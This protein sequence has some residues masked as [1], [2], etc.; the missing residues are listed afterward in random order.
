MRNTE[1]YGRFSSCRGVAFEIKPHADLF[2]I[3]DRSRLTNQSRRS[4]GQWRSSFA[5]IIPSSDLIERSL[6]RESSHFCDLD[7]DEDEDGDVETLA[8]IEESNKECIVNP[9]KLHLIIFFPRLD[10]P[11]SATKKEPPSSRLSVILLDQGLFT[12]YKRLFAVCLALN[13]TALV[14]AATGKFPYA[15]DR[16]ALFSIANIFALVLCC[17]E[18]VL[19]VVFWLAVTA[20]GHPW[21]PLRLKPMTTALLQS[22]VIV[23]SNPEGSRDVVDA[24]KANGIATFGPIWDSWISLPVSSSSETMNRGKREYDFIA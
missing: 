14:L 22:L 4:W 18:A 11:Q 13:I 19:R 24:C 3:S 9:T 8:D 10:H 15:S 21:I 2:A 6:S 17:S 1:K 23:T 12:V 16:P 5:R 7:D 20:L